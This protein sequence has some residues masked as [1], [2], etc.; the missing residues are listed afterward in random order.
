MKLRAAGA[1]ILLIS[2]GIGDPVQARGGGHGGSHIGHNVQG[3]EMG[4][5]RGIGGDFERAGFPGHGLENAAALGGSAGLEQEVLLN[6]NYADSAY[7]PSDAAYEE[8]L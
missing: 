5:A 6:S 7:F 8:D 4:R 3:R 2:L 1:L